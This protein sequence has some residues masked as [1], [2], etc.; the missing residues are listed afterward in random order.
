L[1]FFFQLP[2]SNV[3]VRPKVN[4]KGQFNRRDAKSAEE[5]KDE[6]AVTE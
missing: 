5:E 3:E 6:G 4:H 2:T 1:N